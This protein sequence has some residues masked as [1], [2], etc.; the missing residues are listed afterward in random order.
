MFVTMT[1]NL[2]IFLGFHGLTRN[3][4]N[5]TL[6]MIAADVT[7]SS[8]LQAANIAKQSQENTDSPHEAI[9]PPAPKRQALSPA[10]MDKHAKKALWDQRKAE[11]ARARAQKVSKA[12][13][14]ASH[15][16][17]GRAMSRKVCLL[18]RQRLSLHAPSLCWKAFLVLQGCSFRAM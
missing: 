18:G 3:W 9:E 4:T 8:F 2:S 16:T 5:D 15:C 6:Q 12:A 13:S 11:R 10:G 17:T 7:A 14:L 1:F